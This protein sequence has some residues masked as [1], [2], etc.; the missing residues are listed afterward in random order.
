MQHN[1]FWPLLSFSSIGRGALFTLTLWSWSVSMPTGN[2]ELIDFVMLPFFPLLLPSV[3]SPSAAPSS[4]SNFP[5]LFRVS[6]RTWQIAH[7]A[8]LAAV[9]AYFFLA[10]LAKTYF[11]KIFNKWRLATGKRQFQ[12]RAHTLCSV[13][14][15]YLA[16]IIFNFPKSEACINWPY[17]IWKMETTNFSIF[18]DKHLRTALFYSNYLRQFFFKFGQP[19][20]ICL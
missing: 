7:P 3:S 6:A 13:P 9:G 18:C 8:A 4:S 5:P 17:L 19:T 2:V 10:M 15:F 16:A 14:F 20:N 11:R 12:L 1:N